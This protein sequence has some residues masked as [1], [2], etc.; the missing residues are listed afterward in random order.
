MWTDDHQGAN[1]MTRERL[2]VLDSGQ[3][4]VVQATDPYGLWHISSERGPV[5]DE[6]KDQKFTEF[7]Y[8][9]DRIRRWAADKKAKVVEVK[10]K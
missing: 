10:R 7:E 2:V 8:A 9:L 3:K 5:A 1:D 6:L 4:L